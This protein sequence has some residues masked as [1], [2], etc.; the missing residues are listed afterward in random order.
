MVAIPLWPSVAHAD[1][2]SDR[3]WVMRA[4]H[5]LRRLAIAVGLLGAFGIVVILPAISKPL[6]GE[7]V[8]FDLG[9]TVPF[10]LLFILV[11][12]GMLHAFVL[13]GLGAAGAV[14]IVTIAQGALGLAVLM[15]TIDSLGAAAVGLSVLTSA[16]M[17]TTWS[18][19][20]I[21]FRRLRAAAP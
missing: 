20:M 18:L 9:I 5:R 1:A 19:P 6:F 8:A 21:L 2:A 10:A 12:W 13:F 16:L 7:S 17:T 14:G 15:V 4:Y 11:C 3:D